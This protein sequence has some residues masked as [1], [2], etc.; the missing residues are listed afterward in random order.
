L[1]GIVLVNIK[2]NSDFSSS[3]EKMDNAGRVE[4]EVLPG[5]RRIILVLSGI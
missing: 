1:I 3:S 5:V 4:E 2:S